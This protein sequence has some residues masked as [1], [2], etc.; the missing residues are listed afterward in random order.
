MA[1]QGEERTEKAT[2]KRRNKLRKEGRVAK[3][4]EINSTA[5]LLATLAALAI[6]GSRLLGAMEKIVHD[7]LARTGQPG[8][9]TDGPGLASLV[10]SSLSSFAWAVAPVAA[11]AAAAGVIASVSQVGLHFSTKALQ[12]SFQ[13][14]NIAAGLKRMFGVNQSVELA[15]SLVKVSI[16]GGI[17]GTAIWS[18]MSSFGGMVGLPP[19]QMLV[20]LA[21]L[22]LSIGFEVGAAL[23]VVAA[24]D[25][26]WQRH[27]HQK[28]AKM[29]KDEVKREARE[30]D[31]P[32]ELR[33]QIRR[34]QSEA[35]RKRMVADVPTADVVVVNPTHYAVAL[36]YDGTKP[37]PEVVAKGVDY[38]ALTIRRIAEEAGV[39]VV[40]EAP[41]AR[42][43]YRDVDLGHMIP[44]EFFHAVAEVL[45]FVFRTAGR[46]RRV[47]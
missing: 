22:V 6:D 11:A 15:K 31:L 37:A 4:M 29:T 9:V 33:G 24:F 2:P 8:L 44:E 5:V 19:G 12:P 34:K 27:K 47:A 42:A 3:S 25:Y 28:S 36:R 39:T 20:T 40:H 41:L 18:R 14:L 26:L 10:M 30:A 17:G 23:F 32:P 13:K 7:G 45:A 35:A 46:R 43:L 38:L 1:Q 21:G 16:V